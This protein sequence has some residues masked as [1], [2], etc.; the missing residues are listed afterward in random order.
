[1]QSVSIVPADPVPCHEA[2]A[3][4]GDAD[5][6]VIG[7]GSWFTSVLPHFLVPDL[8]K[9]IVA[10]R[11]RKIVVLNLD[12]QPGETSGFMPETHLEA[13]GRHAEGL[14]LDVVVA[15]AASVHY[16]ER[17]ETAAAAYGARVLFA[18]VR[19]SDGA[20]QHDPALLAAALEQALTEG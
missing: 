18:P 13:L 9:A 16:P 2:L 10:S 4:I 14:R 12:A 3:A 19:A 20:P 15:D 6:I 1:V 11:A 8:R 7:P 17:L 5:A